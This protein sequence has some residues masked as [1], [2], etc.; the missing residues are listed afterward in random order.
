MSKNILRI[1][2]LSA[3]K[4]TLRLPAVNQVRQCNRGY[5]YEL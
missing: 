2:A 3:S 4:G 5:A 1:E